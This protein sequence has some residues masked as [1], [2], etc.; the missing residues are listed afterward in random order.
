MEEGFRICNECG[1]KYL[2]PNSNTWAYKRN[3]KGKNIYMCK[4]SCLLGFDKKRGGN[5]DGRKTR[6]R[7]EDT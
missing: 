6:N 4:Y 1:S 5:V 7:R 3:V 2:V